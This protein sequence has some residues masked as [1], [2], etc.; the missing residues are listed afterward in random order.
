MQTHDS[1]LG[2]ID[3][4]V[5]KHQRIKV[6]VSAK[7]LPGVFSKRAVRLSY[8]GYNASCNED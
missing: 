6:V 5:A 3:F 7:A 1:A 4:F 2:T 8:F